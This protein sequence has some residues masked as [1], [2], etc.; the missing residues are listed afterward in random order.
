MVTFVWFEGELFLRLEFLLSESLHFFGKCSL[1]WECRINAVSLDRNDKVSAILDEILRVQSQ[2]SR[3]IRLCNVGEYYIH[4]SYEHSVSLRITC[5]VNYGDN[6]GSL[7]G[8]VNEISATTLRKF[9][10]VDN[11]SLQS[12]KIKEEYLSHDV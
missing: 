10:G 11:S 7:L 3:L 12:V 5:I 8:H 9:H 2:D 6:V 4:H 1:C